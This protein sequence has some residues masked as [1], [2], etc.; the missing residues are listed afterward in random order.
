MLRRQECSTQGRG[1]LFSI[2]SLQFDWV[3]ALKNGPC[4][5]W[6]VV[7]QAWPPRTHRCQHAC[8]TTPQRSRTFSRLLIG[9]WRR[10]LTSL[11]RLN[12][13][14]FT[15]ARTIIL[16]RD[17]CV[18][19]MRRGI[20]FAAVRSKLIQLEHENIGSVD[21]P[22]EGPF[23]SPSEEALDRS[24]SRS[25]AAPAHPN[26]S[27]HI[28]L[29]LNVGLLSWHPCIVP[30]SGEKVEKLQQHIKREDVIMKV[31]V[32]A[33][34]LV[35][36]A[37]PSRHRLRAMLTEASWQDAMLDVEGKKALQQQLGG[38]EISGKYV[39][40]A[41][42]HNPA[43]STIPGFVSSIALRAGCWYMPCAS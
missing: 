9:A 20:G 11:V 40:A 29:R 25:S 13:T 38:V 42:L 15:I 36:S 26:S 32:Q 2:N 7:I 28:S 21:S 12:A 22:V 37:L 4:N 8:R 33:A 43:P 17:L 39:R 34:P 24:W 5:M 10:D 30:P 31:P 23:D 3:E 41:L 1:L 16:T 35:P 14:Q 19:T 27:L 18:L 6:H